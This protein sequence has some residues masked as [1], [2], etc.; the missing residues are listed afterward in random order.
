MNSTIQASGSDT[1]KFLNA[2]ERISREQENICALF[3]EL[4]LLMR[5]PSEDV[6]RVLDQLLRPMNQSMASLQEQIRET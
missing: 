1:I 3:E 4:A 5:L 2:L 6:L